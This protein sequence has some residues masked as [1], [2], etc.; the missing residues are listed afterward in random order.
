MNDIDWS[1]SE[2]Y[3][4]LIAHMNDGCCYPWPVSKARGYGFIRLPRSTGKN[5]FIRT[6]RLVCTIIH[7]SPPS[8]K[9]QARHLCGKGHLG[10]FNAAC[11]VWGSRVD[12]EAD[13]RKHGN[14]LKG[15]RH[16]M[17]KLTWKKVTKIRKT[18]GVSCAFLARQYG[19][20]YS[21]ISQI[22]RNKIW[23]SRY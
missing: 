8:D 16:N 21:L 19:V 1:G 3:Q 13:K 7:G 11:L 6:A 12:N 14:I 18:T 15:E 10:C 4:Y 23:T 20:S 9:S 22:K 2:V 5:G 17:V